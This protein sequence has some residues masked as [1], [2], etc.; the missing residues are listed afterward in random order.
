MFYRGEIA[1]RV[2]ADMEANGGFLSREDLES[3][4]PIIREP[5]WGEYRGHRVSTNAPPGG[6]HPAPRN[7]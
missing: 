1:D 3:Y 2:V 5:H 6:R 4:A 7:A